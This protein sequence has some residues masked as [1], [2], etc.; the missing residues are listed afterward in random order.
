MDLST[1]GATCR[2][3]IIKDRC[4]RRTRTSIHV[5][6]NQFSPIFRLSLPTVRGSQWIPILTELRRRAHAAAAAPRGAPGVGEAPGVGGE[7]PVVAVRQEAEAGVVAVAVHDALHALL[8]VVAH[9]AD[10]AVATVAVG[11]GLAGAGAA[12]AGA[13]PAAAAAPAATAVA[14]SASWGRGTLTR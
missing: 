14:A 6:K 11:V 4:T 13:T 1:S 8:V 7:A 2:H 5:G 9:A 12:A 3:L 10:A